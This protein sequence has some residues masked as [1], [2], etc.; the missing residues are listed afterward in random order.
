VEPPFVRKNIA[1]I[2]AGTLDGL[3]MPF[4]DWLTRVAK[5]RR[6]AARGLTEQAGR[7]D[8]IQARRLISR[9]RAVEDEAARYDSLAQTLPKL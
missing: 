8:D 7:S 1:G 5:E 6:E 4:R 3:K 2:M 9:A